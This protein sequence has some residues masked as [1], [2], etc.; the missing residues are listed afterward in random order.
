[1]DE[2]GAP[3]STQTQKGSVQEVEV[4]ADDPEGV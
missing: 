3:D 2:K 1:M 4:E